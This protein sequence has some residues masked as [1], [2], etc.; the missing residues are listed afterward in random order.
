MHKFSLLQ[1][2]RYRVLAAVEELVPTVDLLTQMFGKQSAIE[3]MKQLLQDS[4]GD[5]ISLDYNE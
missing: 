1:I 2:D 5:E 3:Q 4:A